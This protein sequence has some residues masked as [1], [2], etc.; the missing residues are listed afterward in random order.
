MNQKHWFLSNPVMDSG[1][2]S[3]TKYLCQF[4]CGILKMVGPKKQDFGQKSTYS[5]EFFLEKSVDEL[6]FIKI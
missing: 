5:K 6:R 3:A 4:G 1:K 2:I